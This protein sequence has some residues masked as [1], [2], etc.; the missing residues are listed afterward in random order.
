MRHLL[1]IAL[2]SLLTLSATAVA[3]TA[4][5]ARALTTVTITGSGY[6]HGKGL[7]QYGAQGAAKKG[8]TSPQV[9]DFYYP[10]TAT[11]SAGGKIK[12]LVTAD[13]TSSVVVAHRSGLTVR[14]LKKHKTWKLHRSGARR[15][16]LSSVGATKTKLSV[17]STGKWKM[18]RVIPGEAEFRAAGNAPIK[19]L[20]PGGS[21]AYRGALR[22]A[23]PT[24][25]HGRDTVNVVSL[26]SYLRG[27]VPRE[28]PASWM[29]AA[30][31]AQAVAARTYAASE[32]M[33]NAS[34]YF[35]VYDTTLS[36][37]YGGQAAEAAGS[38]AAIRATR[39]LIRTWKG[40]PA[41]TQFSSSNGGYT[42]PGPA[43]KPYLVAK[44]DP[45][46]PA[47]PWDPEVVVS[48][49]KIEK[50]WPQIGQ[51]LSISV[52]DRDVSGR[53]TKLLLHG[54]TGDSKP[55]GDSFRSILGLRSTKFTLTAS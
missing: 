47:S 54:S 28:M 40:A 17:R 13:T 24:S 8:L 43:D 52:T 21:V 10:G 32:R 26:D 45:Y 2:T 48:A 25:G 46:D 35:H 6:G 30:V 7:S 33:Y 36:Q 34:R 11:G 20:V 37:V 3:P 5:A 14:S 29:P 12:V 16:R 23:V 49:A 41:F 39:G 51:L 1:G 31:Q 27:V 50:A 18:I 38:D 4:D 42:A 44:K 22:S 15:W 19:L 53:A 55:S 9:L